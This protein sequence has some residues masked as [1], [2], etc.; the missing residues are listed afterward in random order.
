MIIATLD[1]DILLR[2]LDDHKQRVGQYRAVNLW[3]DR[4]QYRSGPLLPKS[5]TRLCYK[6]YY[7]ALSIVESARVRELWLLNDYS[8]AMVDM[9][10][11]S[12]NS[13]L[14][15]SVFRTVLSTQAQDIPA[16]IKM[17]MDDFAHELLRIVNKAK[18]IGY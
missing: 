11:T 2:F 13:H 12:D 3:E 8:F 4:C 10:I 15:I 18:Q 1:Y 14:F 17:S 7:G 16:K 6:E 5:A 9:V